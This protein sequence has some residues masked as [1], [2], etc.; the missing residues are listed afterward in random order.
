MSVF[1]HSSYVFDLD[2]VIMFSVMN[3]RIQSSIL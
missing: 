2:V 1:L 3:I